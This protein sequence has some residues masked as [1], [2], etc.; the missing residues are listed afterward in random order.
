MNDS[1]YGLTASVWT[2]DQEVFLKLVP[3]I[4]AGMVFMNGC[5]APDPALPWTGIKDSGRGVSMSQFAFDGFTQVKGVD[6]RIK[7]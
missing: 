7:V 5:D 2:S 1:R 6:V 3:Q 4:E